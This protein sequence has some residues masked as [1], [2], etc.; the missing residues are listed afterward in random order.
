M[1]VTF[2]IVQRFL[3]RLGGR[4]GLESQVCSDARCHRRSLSAT[5]ST[6][7]LV[8]GG[9]P[10]SNFA[11]NLP[12]TTY[13]LLTHKCAFDHSCRTMS[14]PGFAQLMPE[15]QQALLDGPALAPPPGATPNL[16]SPSNGNSLVL[17]VTILCLSVVSLL[18]RIRAY[19]R[20]FG[21]RKIRLEDCGWHFLSF[22][23]TEDAKQTA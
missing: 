14:L 2:C 7:R 16:T 11:I 23:D 21:L 22:R 10:A 15:K 12:S 9:H 20:I 19:S 5:T 4:R 6:S 1:A 8:H 3:Q 13:I 17:V 18:V